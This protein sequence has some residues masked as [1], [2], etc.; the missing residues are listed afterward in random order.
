[1]LTGTV[2]L[3]VR[4][5]FTLPSCVPAMSFENN[6]AELSA[7]MLLPFKSHPRVLELGEVMDF[8]AVLDGRPPILE[9]LQG[10]SDRI[11][12]GHAPGLSGPGLCAYRGAGI[13]TDPECVT[14]QEARS[15]NP[16]HCQLP[17]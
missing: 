11:I 3:P 14:P 17:V 10:F 12:D 7:Q 8:P 16:F 9:K 15:R 2:E 13:R 5:Y 4:V 1:M 6:G